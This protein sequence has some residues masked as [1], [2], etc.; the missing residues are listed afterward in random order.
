MSPVLREGDEITLGTAPL[1]YKVNKK[2]M[3]DMNENALNNR[4]PFC[5]QFHSE[6][7]AGYITDEQLCN[8][9][10]RVVAQNSKR[11]VDNEN[12]PTL[13]KTKKKLKTDNLPN[14]NANEVLVVPDDDPP[15]ESASVQQPEVGQAQAAK[16]ENTMEVMEDEMTCSICSELFVKTMTLNCSHSFCKSCINTWMLNK[17]ICPICR[18]PIKDLHPTIVLDNFIEKVF[19]V[20]GVWSGRS[21]HVDFVADGVEGVGGGEGASQADRRGS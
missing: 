13:V 15:V 5:V 8:F 1:I 20:C 7:E 18:T 19:G 14:R 11:T 6:I 4:W 16:N 9:A 10:D 12:Q 17:K 2:I 21:V 3:Y